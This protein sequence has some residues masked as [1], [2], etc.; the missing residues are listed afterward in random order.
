[1]LHLTSTGHAELHGRGLLRDYPRFPTFEKRSR[2]SEFT[3]RHELAVM[4]MKA[5][6]VKSARDS[7]SCQVH[8]FSTW[9]LLSQFKARPP[10]ISAASVQET[11]VKPDGFIHVTQLKP[12]ADLKRHWFYLEIDR[13]TEPQE[14]LAARAACYRDH[15][16]R[17]GLAAR[18]S[19]P[20]ERYREFPFR[21]L[22]VF[23]N[24]ERRNN[25]AAKMLLLQ[26]PI[27]TLTWMTTMNEAM[28]DPLGP[29]WIQPV[30][31]RRVVTGTEYEPRPLRHGD[32]YRRQPQRELMVEEKIEKHSLF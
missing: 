18:Y 16:R 31:Y 8:E 19:Q 32:I 17:G 13:S 20:R 7:A 12:K 15:F 23:P 5:A 3:L 1:M 11:L 6:F 10:T 30:D 2:V 25:S 28:A 22:M 26:P 29:I 4:D 9:P 14:T 24:A 21:V 27:L